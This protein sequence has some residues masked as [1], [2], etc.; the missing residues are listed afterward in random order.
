MLALYPP[1]E[2]AR[3]SPRERPLLRHGVAPLNLAYPGDQDARIV[4]YGPSH[5]PKPSAAVCGG[6]V[7]L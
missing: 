4:P 1:I 2:L 3:N 7:G 6:A 5:G